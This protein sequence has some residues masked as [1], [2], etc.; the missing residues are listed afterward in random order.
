VPGEF[1]TR[2][3][4]GFST[5]TVAS[6]RLMWEFH[7]SLEIMVSVGYQ[8]PALPAEFSGVEDRLGTILTTLKKAE[9]GQGWIARGYAAEERSP[10]LAFR[11][12]KHRVV[13][14][15]SLGEAVDSQPPPLDEELR[16]FEIRSVR[17]ESS[18]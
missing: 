2:F 15:V 18:P 11:L 1:I 10:W 13:R 17:I 7:N 12:P 9:D 5:D 8:S 4:L 14:R 16:P 3:L 6:H